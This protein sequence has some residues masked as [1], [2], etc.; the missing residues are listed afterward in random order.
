MSLSQ[1]PSPSAGCKWRAR[2]RTF[3]L[4][5]KS[6][7]ATATGNIYYK[8]QIYKKNL[9]LKINSPNPKDLSSR[10]T[11]STDATKLSLS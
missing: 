11:P 1:T 6:Q 9:C 3:A 8:S 10:P 4:G 5:S 7:G 2:Q